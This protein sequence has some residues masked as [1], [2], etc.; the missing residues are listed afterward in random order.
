MKSLREYITEATKSHYTPNGVEIVA[1]YVALKRELKV[2]CQI[3]FDDWNGDKSG[4]TYPNVFVW[5]MPP[6]DSEKDPFDA[7]PFGVIEFVDHG[8]AFTFKKIN[9]RDSKTFGTEKELNKW[10]LDNFEKFQEQW[11]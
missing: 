7:E 9:G 6:K 10:L 4:K 5:I 2:K 8:D 3:D 1:D 11:Y